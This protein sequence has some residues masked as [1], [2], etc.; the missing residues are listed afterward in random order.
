MN[1]TA[2]YLSLAVLISLLVGAAE[3]APQRRLLI[4]GVDGCRPDALLVADTPNVDQLAADGASSFHSQTGDVP[5][6]GPGWS[7]MFT[8]VWRNKHGVADNSF[9][10]ARFDL[11]PIFFCRLKDQRPSAVTQSIVRWQPLKDNLITCADV[12]LYPPS[13][14]AAAAE[15]ARLLRETDP[16]ALFVH[17]NAPD[18]AGHSVGFS[19]DS[20][21]YIAAIE[22][23]DANIGVILDALRS[24]AAID[25]EDWLVIV[26]TDHGGSG[27]DHHADVPENRTTF[28][29][30]S[31]S[32]AARGEIEPPPGIVDVAATALE[33]LGVGVFPFP[34]W[35]LDGRPVGLASEPTAGRQVPSDCTQDGSL[36]VSDAICL[37]GYLF[38]ARPAPCESAGGQLAL[39]DSNGDGEADVSDAVHLLLHLFGGG[40]GPVLGSGCSPIPGCPELCGG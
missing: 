30:V 3:A 20:S 16:E 19:P 28:L 8:G 29:I 31:G 7:S 17:L 10:G 11:Y 4:I 27:M 12:S 38:L 36:D 26:T 14:A 9:A 5:I 33:F 24:R 13:D 22:G 39:L 18:T 6:S 2:V 23:V 15:A 25:S 37:L 34:A 21:G 32:S 40:A 1:T 35:D